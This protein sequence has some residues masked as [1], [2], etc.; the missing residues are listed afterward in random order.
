M[1][2]YFAT[3]NAQ[4]KAKVN[5]STDD[6]Q[7]S[8]SF[9]NVESYKEFTKQPKDASS[10]SSPNAEKHFLI[11]KNILLD[12]SQGGGAL[13]DTLIRLMERNYVTIENITLEKSIN[14]VYLESFCNRFG[15]S[16]AK[17]KQFLSQINFKL[18]YA[19]EAD[20]RIRSNANSFA[21][22]VAPV[23]LGK[24]EKAIY[25]AHVYNCQFGAKLPDIILYRNCLT[26]ENVIEWYVLAI[27]V[28]AAFGLILWL[29]LYLQAKHKNK[30][31]PKREN[32]GNF[33]TNNV[34]F[35]NSL[36]SKAENGNIN[37]DAK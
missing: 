4:F 12:T 25:T 10:S 19:F 21:T 6:Y 1:G 7:I 22:L 5:S 3:E 13:L 35:D 29:A 14:Q 34:N 18:V 36:G 33:S 15:M 32:N 31:N 8:I 23:G 9:E 20:E 2:G 17:A 16:E 30:Y 26:R 11:S 37:E 28:S 27:G 24:D